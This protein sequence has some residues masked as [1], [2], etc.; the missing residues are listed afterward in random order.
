KL[1]ETTV[2][3]SPSFRTGPLKLIGEGAPIGK[4]IEFL[5]RELKIAF[6]DQTGLQGKYNYTLDINAFVTPEMRRA[7]GNGPPLEAPSIIG[8]ALREQ[9]GLKLDSSK[10]S[11]P[12]VVIDHIEKEATEN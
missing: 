2:E 4:M 12:V 6:L 5:S 8:T 1:R 9:L 10:A 7:P 3:G 11:I